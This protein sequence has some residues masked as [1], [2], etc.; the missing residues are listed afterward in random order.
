M[1]YSKNYRQQLI[2]KIVDFGNTTEY[3]ILHNDNIESDSQSSNEDNCSS[4][5]SCSNMDV[6]NTEEHKEQIISKRE[7]IN[8][9]TF[10]H[11]SHNDQNIIILLKYTKQ[12]DFPVQR[13]SQD[14][15]W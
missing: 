4:N 13:K 9:K 11:H 5:D 2:D 8:R 7:Q 12:G 15:L 14:Y 3:E 1:E 10:V 6:D